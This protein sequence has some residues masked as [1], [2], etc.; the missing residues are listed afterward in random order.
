M[1]PQVCEDCA[2]A[3]V[4]RFAEDADAAQ[5]QAIYAPYCESA[6]VSFETVAPT[7]AEMAARIGKITPQ[8]P[9]LVADEGGNVAGYVY[10]SPHRERAA[11]QWSVDVAAYVQSTRHR[12][13]LGRALYTTLC[14]VLAL[15]GY[16]KAYAGV[17]LPNPA[18]VGLHQAVG[19]EPVGIY[20]G[21]GYKLGH[22]IDTLWLQKSLQPEIPEPLPPR[23]LL[24]IRDTPAVHQALAEGL[25][26]LSRRTLT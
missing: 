17:A 12:T 14:R 22:W 13:G 11:Y 10:A 24:E 2:V 9:W 8:F 16:F 26:L 6:A 19:F 18:S 4:I 15:Q 5:L 23:R 1:S 25:A 3:L 20:R 7:V 21:V